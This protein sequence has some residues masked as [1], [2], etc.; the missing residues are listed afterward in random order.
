MRN[1]VFTSILFFAFTNCLFSQVPFRTNTH[2]NLVDKNSGKKIIAEDFEKIDPLGI[3]FFIVTHKNG[4]KSLVNSKGDA[5][6][7]ANYVDFSLVGNSYISFT[8]EGNYSY[9]Q[10]DVIGGNWGL[11]DYSGKIIIEPKFHQIQYGSEDFLIVQVEGN[12][13]NWGVIDYNGNWIEKA[14]YPSKSFD[15]RPHTTIN[16]IDNSKV[17]IEKESGV[18]LIK[19]LKTKKTNQLKYDSPWGPWFVDG[20]AVIYLEN[21]DSY[22][23]NSNG[24]IVIPKGIASFSQATGNVIIGENK[25][26]EKIYLYTKEGK[27]LSQWSGTLV[28]RIKNGYAAIQTKEGAIIIDSTG[29]TTYQTKNKL[30]NL[31]DQRY[32][33]EIES[34]KQ[35]SFVESSSGRKIKLPPST[36][37]ETIV[38]EM[39]HAIL[40]QDI[41]TVNR[42]VGIFNLATQKMT[43]ECK[44]WDIKHWTKDVY[45]VS[46]SYSESAYLNGSTN[47]L[48][49]DLKPMYEAIYFRNEYEVKEKFTAKN[50]FDKK[51]KSVKKVN[52]S[53]FIADEN[54]KKILLHAGLRKVSEEFDQIETQFGCWIVTKKG[55]NGVLNEKLELV[56]P[57]AFKDIKIIGEKSNPP[58]FESLFMVRQNKKWG[59]IASDG[60]ILMDTIHFNIYNNSQLIYGDKGTTYPNREF[61]YIKRDGTPIPQLEGALSVQILN[62]SSWYI[63][64]FKSKPSYL[65]NI[66]TSKTLEIPKGMRI[67]RIVNSNLKT[68]CFY[69]KKD[70]GY[71]IIDEN[72]KMIVSAKDY[73]EISPELSAVQF[74]NGKKGAVVI[75]HEGDQL[76]LDKMENLTIAQYDSQN[77]S[78]EENK[79]WRY[80]LKNGKEFVLVDEN[81]KQIGNESYLSL[82]QGEHFIIATNKQ[83]KVGGIDEN[84]KVIVPF[85]YD[86]HIF[87]DVWNFEVFVKNKK[88]YLYLKDGKLCISNLSIDEVP[89][90]DF[91]DDEKTFVVRSNKKLILFEIEHEKVIMDNILDLQFDEELYY[92]NSEANPDGEKFMLITLESGVGLYSF[93]SNTFLIQPQFS[94]IKPLYHYDSESTFLLTKNEKGYNLYDPKSKQFAFQKEA[95]E[96]LSSEKENSVFAFLVNEKIHLVHKL[97]DAQ[98]FKIVPTPFGKEKLTFQYNFDLIVNENEVL[99]G[100]DILK[101]KKKGMILMNGTLLHPP[102]L[103]N[104]ESEVIGG[105]YILVKKEG[106][107]YIIDLNGNYIFQEGFDLI[108]FMLDG[109]LLAIGSIKKGKKYLE[110]ELYSDGTSKKK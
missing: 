58:G 106:K 64:D 78:T 75:T 96:F 12:W 60:K 70:K 66:N 90:Y 36:T 102:T 110:V 34:D 71:G 35:H 84:G 101:G 27:M 24:K 88:N 63:V 57:V 67:Q 104:Y 65:F 95:E 79:K 59:L 56:V 33:I 76:R 74:L 2:W 49:F 11:M 77:Y 68:M 37:C 44:Y 21:D 87:T 23:I 105:K 38:P 18:W 50:V 93:A 98:T 99:D 29:K 15:M 10:G 22:V 42:K 108:E 69:F 100:I 62:Y 3:N 20:L 25:S 85:E 30:D 31:N 26:K 13:G 32:F 82:Y 55:L 41:G 7:E 52:D 89:Y 14:V 43:V 73:P 92:T 17:I 97:F 94:E 19:D 103:D 72:G 53:I 91:M 9:I 5:I 107:T 81:L 45:K 61:S 51:F 39:N 8:A 86:S 16:M 83:N 28:S 4:K 6:S 48:Y 1:F 109:N 46:F 54:G 40:I 47:Q 80:S